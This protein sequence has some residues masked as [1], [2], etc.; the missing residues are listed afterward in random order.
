MALDRTITL[1][2]GNRLM[3][4]SRRDVIKAIIAAFSGHVI[5]VQFNYDNIRVVFNKPEERTEALTN[6]FVKL[7][8]QNIKI[9]G[10]GSPVLTVVLFD[11]PFEGPMEPVI[12]ALNRYGEYKNFRFQK[13]RYD[14][15][16]VYTGSQLIRMILRQQCL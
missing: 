13:F 3:K 16:S 12:E 1:L 2:P 15:M 4:V 6:P 14:D 10:G 8:G 7:C 9:D 11:Y 5:S